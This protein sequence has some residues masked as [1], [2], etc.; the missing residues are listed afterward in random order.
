MTA[1]AASFLAGFLSLLS[2]REALC[3]RAES[4]DEKSL[5]MVCSVMVVSGALVA[6]QPTNI[7]PSSDSASSS[8]VLCS[9]PPSTATPLPPSILLTDMISIVD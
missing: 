5:I 6:F 2:T 1:D 7:H 8:N 3:L 4:M 9:P